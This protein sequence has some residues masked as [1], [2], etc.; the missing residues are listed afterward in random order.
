MADEVVDVF[1]NPYHRTEVKPHHLDLDEVR[2]ACFDAYNIVTASQALGGEHES[3][4]DDDD[5]EL[6]T[7]FKL[8]LELAEGRLSQLL[9]RVALMLRTFD[10]IMRDVPG[11]D[12]HVALTSGKNLIGEIDGEP[13]SLR[14]ACN[15]IIHAADFRPVYESAYREQPDETYSRVW[16]M[17]GEVEI[18]GMRGEHQWEVLLFVP[19]F[20]ELVLDRIAFAPPAAGADAA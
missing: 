4:Y 1:E 19:P 5:A 9:L 17:T 12:A 18:G 7:L 10:D 13:L 6:S 11:Y 2:L 15:K 14:E 16:Y 3:N 8:H 20:L